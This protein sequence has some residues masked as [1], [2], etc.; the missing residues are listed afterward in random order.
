MALGAAHDGW[1]PVAVPGRFEPAWAIEEDVAAVPPDARR[2]TTPRC[3]SGPTGC[4]TCPYIWGGVSAYGVDCSGL[5][6][7]AWR[8][9]G[10][11]LPRDA[12][13]QAAAH[14]ADPARARS[15]P[16]TSTSSPGPGRPIHHVGFVAAVRRTARARSCTPATCRAGSCWRPAPGDR[17]ATLVGV[18]PH[19]RLSAVRR[20]RSRLGVA[21]PSVEALVRGALVAASGRCGPALLGLPVELTG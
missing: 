11:T 4:A 20:S 19:P 8:R 10:V 17:A 18:A 2:P 15:A 5:V 13:D 21:E 1:L 12:H 16:A 14:R 6:H 7:L 3:S 9:F